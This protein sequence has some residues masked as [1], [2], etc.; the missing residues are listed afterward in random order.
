METI[1]I[2]IRAALPWVAI[3]LFVGVTLSAKNVEKKG[4]KPSGLMVLLSWTPLFCFLLVALL[5]LLDGDL[6]DAAVWLVLG[7]A[8]AFLNTRKKSGE[9]EQA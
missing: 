1:L 7:I 6:S 5:E 4:E 3:G 9:Q 2:F 8:N